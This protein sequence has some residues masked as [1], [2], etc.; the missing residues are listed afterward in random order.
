MENKTT[1]TF[2]KSPTG[3]YKKTVTETYQKV[4]TENLEAQKQSRLT[5]IAGLQAE[6][7]QADTDIAKIEALLD[8]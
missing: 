8:E 3:V 2:V 4:T 7:T 6:N 5:R 1:T